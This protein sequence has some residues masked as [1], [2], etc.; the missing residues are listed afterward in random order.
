MVREKIDFQT[1]P[2]RE[3]QQNQINAMQNPNVLQKGTFVYCSVKKG[4]AGSFNRGFQLTDK[5][6]GIIDTVDAFRKP[7]LYTVKNLQLIR[8]HG[9]FVRESLLLAPNPM[10]AKHYYLRKV[11]KNIIAEKLILHFPLISGLGH[12]KRW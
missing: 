8:I 5:I 1:V 6:I 4:R 9:S 2:W 7:I 3:A 11:S 12:C 10:E